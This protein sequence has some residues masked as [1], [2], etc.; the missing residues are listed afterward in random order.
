MRLQRIGGAPASPLDGTWRA[1]S[2]LTLEIQGN[3]YRRFGDGRP[4][5]NG[6]IEIRGQELVIHPAA[7]RASQVPYRLEGDALTLG[8]GTGAAT[9]RRQSRKEGE[10]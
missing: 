1:D 7:G 4:P 3:Q 9:F 8:A 2:G 6:T 5:S 10:R